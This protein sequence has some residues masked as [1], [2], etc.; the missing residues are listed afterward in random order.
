MTKEPYNVA[1]RIF[2]PAGTSIFVINIDKSARHL[3]FSF[4]DLILMPD[5]FSFQAE[6]YGM[7]TE[8]EL[9]EKFTYSLF[10]TTLVPENFYGD[11]YTMPA[12]ILKTIDLMKS[13]ND[14][15]EAK[16]QPTV[17]EVPFFMDWYDTRYWDS[18]ALSWDAFVRDEMALVYYTDGKFNE[19]R[20]F[21]ALPEHA[22]GVKYA[23]NY[24]FPDNYVENEEF[25]RMRLVIAPNVT[26]AWSTDVHLLAMGFSKKQI[27]ER[28][29]KKRL[30]FKNNNPDQYLI[31]Q[32]ENTPL[33][34]LTKFA[35]KIALKPLLSMFTSKKVQA[36][37]SRKDEPD[38]EEFKKSIDAA[39]LELA[40]ETNY[41]V[42]LTYDKDTKKFKFAFT[43]SQTSSVMVLHIDKALSARMGFNLVTDITSA[44]AESAKVD[45][46]V[47]FTDIETK[48]RALTFDT[49]MV[50]VTDDS[51][52]SCQTFGISGKLM[53]V[54]F[55]AVN[56]Q[57]LIMS[58]NNVRRPTAMAPPSTNWNYTENVPITFRMSRSLTDNT[59]SDFTWKFGAYVVGV[60]TGSQ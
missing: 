31:L 48:V 19:A 40:E 53:T 32:A 38:N 30:V 34:D 16:R 43:E 41:P 1:F 59:L 51:T 11:E 4:T 5:L 54:L 23:N 9:A 57:T 46:R 37:V 26:S 58:Q 50:V 17:M 21:N 42:T 56:G 55:P 13:I 2:I 60:L 12:R 15:F 44:N 3:K 18:T 29:A 6:S 27:G 45:D 49:N 36:V 24:R 35:L 8:E 14:A 10:L 33:W 7:D 20:D 52:N 39:L 28:N 22:R 25:L 47:D